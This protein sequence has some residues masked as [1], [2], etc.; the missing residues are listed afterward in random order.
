MFDCD[1]KKDENFPV[2]SYDLCRDGTLKMSQ[3]PCFEYFHSRR[4]ISKR[5][6]YSDS[7]RKRKA[8]AGHLDENDIDAQEEPMGGRWMTPFVDIYGRVLVVLYKNN[9]LSK[10]RY[11]KLLVSQFSKYEVYF[12]RTLNP[13]GQFLLYVWCSKLSVSACIGIKA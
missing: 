2:C 10:I 4:V 3:I 1:L 11:C 13:V 6:L 12:S 9:C 8:L 7:T 5:V